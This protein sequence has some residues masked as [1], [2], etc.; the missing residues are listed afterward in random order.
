[1]SGSDVRFLIPACT[2]RSS[3]RNRQ[4]RGSCIGPLANTEDAKVS[5]IERIFHSHGDPYVTCI[6]LDFASV[7]RLT[8]YFLISDKYEAG[9]RAFRYMNAANRAKNGA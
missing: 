9:G 1:M 7:D 8:F 4:G 5:I 2:V 6:G 3:V